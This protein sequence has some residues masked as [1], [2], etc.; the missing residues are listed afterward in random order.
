MADLQRYSSRERM[1]HGLVLVAFLLAALTGFA[2]FYPGLY[3]LSALVGGGG[4]ARILHPF[5]G[6]VVVLGFLG[7]F[8]RLRGDNKIT[9]G[10]RVWASRMGELVR[11]NKKAMPPA[12]K[13]NYGQ[14]MVFWATAV[15][16]LLLFVTGVMFWNPWFTPFFPIVLQRFAVLLHAVAAFGVL[17]VIIVH[18]YAAVWVKG[19]LRAMKDGTV[20]EGWAKANHPLWYEEMRKR[21]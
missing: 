7:L 10:D 1:N 4:I 12:G 21:P 11:G 13:Y 3:F 16:L 14:K 2:F 19:T 6:L 18:A 17:L 20:S 5:L 9:D 8:L 15:C